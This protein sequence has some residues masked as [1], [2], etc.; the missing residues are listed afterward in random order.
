MR[1]LCDHDDHPL[2][3][4]QGERHRLQRLWA[5]L[6]GPWEGSTHP[7]EEGCRADEEEEAEGEA[8]PELEQHPW[9]LSCPPRP[10]V[11]WLLKPLLLGPLHLL[12]LQWTQH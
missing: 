2:E 5:L 1:Q 7:A 6:Q 8:G 4:N 12:L 9:Q 3:E 10:P 11:H